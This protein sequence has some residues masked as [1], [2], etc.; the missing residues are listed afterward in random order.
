MRPIYTYVLNKI[1]RSYRYVFAHVALIR[2]ARQN[3][4]AWEHVRERRLLSKWGYAEP[5][6]V[7]LRIH[8]VKHRAYTVPKLRICCQSA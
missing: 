5:I 6:L 8:G 3:K 2:V 7:M 4:A 1:S